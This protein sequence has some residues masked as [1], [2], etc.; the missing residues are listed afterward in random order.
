MSGD[1]LVQRA[2]ADG[3]HGNKAAFQ[4]ILENILHRDTDLSDPADHIAGHV[5]A[6]LIRDGQALHKAGIDNATLRKLGFR[7]MIT[8]IRVQTIL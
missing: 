7:S 1:A 5:R 8:E 3:S 6:N 4:K 2:I